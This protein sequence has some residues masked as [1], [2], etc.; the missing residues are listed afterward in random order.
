MTSPRTIIDV[1]YINQRSFNESRDIPP[2]Y[3][4]DRHRQEW[5]WLQDDRMGPRVPS[6]STAIRNAWDDWR[7]HNV[8]PGEIHMTELRNRKFDLIDRS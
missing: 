8:M 3:S 6:R 7:E 5:F 2:G 4:I 1:L